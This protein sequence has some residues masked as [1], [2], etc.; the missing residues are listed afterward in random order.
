MDAFVLPLQN[1]WDTVI[2]VATSRV[3]WKMV[4][5]EH[6]RCVHTLLLLGSQ[7]MTEPGEVSMG[8][9][10]RQQNGQVLDTTQSRLVSS[11]SSWTARHCPISS[12]ASQLLLISGHEQQPTSTEP[13]EPPPQPPAGTWSL[14]QA[15]RLGA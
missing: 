3:A 6:L 8:P 9:G 4:F 11:R 2:F 1:I 10:T 15:A 12:E 14:D 7:P 5:E 13:G